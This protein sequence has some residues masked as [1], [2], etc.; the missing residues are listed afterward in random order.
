[1]SKWYSLKDREVTSS[2]VLVVL[3]VAAFLT[4]LYPLSFSEYPFNNDSLTECGVASEILSTGHLEF[5]P[6]SQWHGTHS[7][8]TPILNLFL[9][10]SSASLGANPIECAQL[11]NAVV[12]LSTIGAIFILVRI[13]SSSLLGATAAGFTS[14]VLGTFVFTTASV[15]K[16]AL[17]FS[18]FAF[19]VLFFVCR[20]RISFRVLALAIIFLIPFVHHLVAAV[21]LLFLSFLVIWSW[22]VAVNRGRIQRRHVMDLAMVGFPVVTAVLYY[23]CVSFD[24]I[25]TFSSPASVLTMVIAFVLLVLSG[26]AVL[27]MKKHSKWTFAP[28]IGGGLIALAVAD[29]YGWIFPYKHSA[30]QSYLLLS[31]VYGFILSVAWYGSEV[32]VEKIPRYR[33][34]QMGLLIAPLTIIAF[35][36]LGGFTLSSHKVLYRSFDFLDMFVFVGVGVAVTTLKLRHRIFYPVL[37]VI[38]IVLALISF[39]FAYESA[40]LLGVRHDTNGYEVDSFE[41][42]ADHA[43]SRWIS[44]DERLARIAQN[45]WGANRDASLPTMIE[46]NLALSPDNFYVIEDDWM[47]LGV[48]NYP[49][50]LVV[51]KESRFSQLM[52]DANVIYIGGPSSD[53][54]LVF[55]PSTLI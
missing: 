39:P 33:A 48:N 32:L 8:A 53:R 11:L 15:W 35:G 18:F 27:S 29:Y 19:A 46:K 17:G 47:T 40:R 37:P 1:M 55:V 34:V 23:Y 22:F 51:V 44:S 45:S 2:L 4:R 13:M 21:V 31:L 12:F 9:A 20:D 54:I 52:D 26:I 3:F 16:E 36:I 43:D 24:R 30:S 28:A 38:L 5:P 50:G 7:V 10:F 25:S 49:Y 6:G 41:W 42:L 14:I